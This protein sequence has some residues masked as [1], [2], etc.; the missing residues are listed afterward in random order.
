M[1]PLNSVHLNIQILTLQKDAI[2]VVSQCR[3]IHKHGYYSLFF[4]PLLSFSAHKLLYNLQWSIY[5]AVNKHHVLKP[6][7][8]KKTSL[9]SKKLKT[10]NAFTRVDVM[11]AEVQFNQYTVWTFTGLCTCIGLLR[12]LHRQQ[13]GLLLTL[14]Q[15]A[16]VN[17]F[18]AN[19]NI[20]THIV[21]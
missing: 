16:G 1:S 17:I 8:L 6:V 12:Q 19:S 20:L 2:T 3:I 4:S 7:R 15:D 18:T 11:S 5:C 14:N 9:S 10:L 21:M 13:L